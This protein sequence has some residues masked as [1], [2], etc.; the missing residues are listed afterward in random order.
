VK[1]SRFFQAPWSLKSRLAFS[2]ML[3]ILILFIAV[4]WYSIETDLAENAD[5]RRQR[6]VSEVADHAKYLDYYLLAMSREVNRFAAVLS[7][8]Q[9][10]TL[11]ELINAEKVILRENP[12]LYGLCIAWEPYSFDPKEKYCCPYQWRTKPVVNVIGALHDSDKARS[13]PVL[14]TPSDEP[15]QLMMFG[16]NPTY[17]YLDNKEWYDAAKKRF[18]SVTRINAEGTFLED[19]PRLQMGIWT[20]PTWDSDIWGVFTCSYSTPIFKNKKFAGTVTLDITVDWIREFLDTIQLKGGRFL[21]IAPD[22]TIVSHPNKD[23]IAKNIKDISEERNPT[24]EWKDVIKTL[25]EYQQEFDYTG[26]IYRKW[27]DLDPHLPKLSRTIPGLSTPDPVYMEAVRLPT[28]GWILIYT[29]PEKSAKL[30]QFTLPK[31][32]I[33]FFLCGLFLFGIALL[34]RIDRYI[35]QPVKFITDAAEEIRKGNFDTTIDIKQSISSD[36]RL[37]EQNFNTMTAVLRHNIEMAVQHATAREAAEKTNRIKGELLMVIG[38]ELR[39]PLNGV[40]GMTDMLLQTALDKKQE[41]YAALTRESGLLLHLL[42]NNMLDFTKREFGG[43][44]LLEKPFHLRKIVNEAKEFLIHQAEF[45]GCAIRTEFADNIGDSFLGDKKHIRQALLNLLAN[46]IKFSKNSEIVIKVSGHPF[47]IDGMH[48]DAHTIQ[49]VR[50]E[51]IDKGCG[52]TADKLAGLFDGITEADMLSNRRHDGMGIGLIVTK[53]FVEAAH[54]TIGVKSTEGKGSV[55]HFTLPLSEVPEDAPPSTIIQITTAKKGV[56]D[57]SVVLPDIKTAP[58]VLI[59]EDNKI[60][61]IVIKELLSKSGFEVTVVD[62]GKKAVDSFLDKEK[63]FD[64]ILMDCQM[65]EMDGYEAAEKIRADEVRRDVKRQIPIIALTANAAPGDK[66]RCLSVGMNAY[67]NKPVNASE[68]LNLMTQLL[69][70]KNSKIT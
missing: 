42:I 26:K 46:A 66:E 39:T 59:A 23:W 6:L 28:T 12:L 29:I 34:W 22:N 44:E 48:P 50:F 37:M 61:Q 1:V 2:V 24:G 52:I 5:Y 17:N 67:C 47:G 43:I 45:Q 49:N 18:P 14:F 38:H 70:S 9:P 53:M 35:V 8:K 65:P 31:G 27:K 7:V 41:E 16:D 25:A 36:M 13:E 54:G 57:S 60:N 68:L 63:H 4:Y 10:K 55:F 56:L 21:V 40:I 3:P 32:N 15:F 69:K 33:A 58:A 19:A 64:L 20:S 62:N 30:Y 11:E 51:V